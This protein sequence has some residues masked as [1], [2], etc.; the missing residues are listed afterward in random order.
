MEISDHYNPFTMLNSSKSDYH[1]MDACDIFAMNLSYTSL[2][3][4]ASDVDESALTIIHQC[5]YTCVCILS[6]NKMIMDE[7]IL[8]IMH[9]K[10]P[11]PITNAILPSISDSFNSLCR[12]LFIFPLRYLFAISFL[13]IFSL[14][15]TNLVETTPL[16]SCSIKQ[17]Y[18]SHNHFLLRYTAPN[19]CLVSNLY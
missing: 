9:I 5:I 19:S 18:S 6:Y 8:P 4:Y 3:T 13:P 10:H 15:C 1:L 17:L 2:L 12:V 14:G 16:S 7:N 11:W